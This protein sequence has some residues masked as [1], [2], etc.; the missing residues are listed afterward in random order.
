MMKFYEDLRNYQTLITEF[1][2]EEANIKDKR[3]TLANLIAIRNKNLTNL[4]NLISE[5]KE[6]KSIVF[7]SANN[8]YIYCLSRFNQTEK[9]VE[10]QIENNNQLLKNYADLITLINSTQQDLTN[11]TSE[12]ETKSIWQRSEYAISWNGVKNIG[13][14]LGFFIKDMQKLFAHFI[15]GLYSSLRSTLSKIIYHPFNLIVFLIKIIFLLFLYWFLRSRLLSSL[16]QA[17]VINPKT[18]QCLFFQS[19]LNFYQPLLTHI[20]PVFLFGVHAFASS[21]L[22]ILPIVFYKYSFI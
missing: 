4:K 20:S 14:D 7:K 21:I 5:L 22:I 10:E 3:N 11:I 17:E 13:S 1:T 6:A 12:L 16:F 8:K 19:L 2:R 9:I 15:F 18:N